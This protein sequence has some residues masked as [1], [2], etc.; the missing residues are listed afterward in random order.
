MAVGGCRVLH[1]PHGHNGRRRPAQR[2]GEG[3]A[4]GLSSGQGEWARPPRGPPTAETTFSCGQAQGGFLAPWRGFRGRGLHLSRAQGGWA[5]DSRL[6]PR[7]RPG[8]RPATAPLLGNRSPSGAPPRP[9]WEEGSRPRRPASARPISEPRWHGSRTARAPIGR[10]ACH[11][12]GRRRSHLRAPRA[13]GGHI[14][15]SS[16]R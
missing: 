10:S 13:M 7:A 5:A 1:S 12:Q 3:E 8:T 15:H 14:P 6:P 11:A 9:F 16:A 2:L 4:P